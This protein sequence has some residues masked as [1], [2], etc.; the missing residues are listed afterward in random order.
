VEESHGTVA[1][2]AAVVAGD[3]AGVR[4]FEDFGLI[5]TETLGGDHGGDD[6]ASA[7]SFPNATF[8]IL[9]EAEV[10]PIRDG[11]QGLVVHLGSFVVGVEMREIRTGNN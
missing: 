2:D 3:V 5:G 6:G 1:D 9:R 4:V 10:I 11:F 8:K 7:A